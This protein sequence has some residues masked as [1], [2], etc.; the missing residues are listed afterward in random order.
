MKGHFCMEFANETK[1]SFKKWKE[2][3]KNKETINL[4]LPS[5]ATGV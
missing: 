3:S 1:Q 4:E 2:K 5:P